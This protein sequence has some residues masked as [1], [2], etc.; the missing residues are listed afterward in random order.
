[1]PP[2]SYSDANLPC[3]GVRVDREGKSIQLADSVT[4]GGAEASAGLGI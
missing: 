1:M 4:R 3:D 2:A